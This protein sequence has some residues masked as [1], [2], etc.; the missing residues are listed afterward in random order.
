MFAPV[1]PSGLVTR[2]P[3]SLGP[4]PAACPDGWQ[5]WERTQA[6]LRGP[7]EAFLNRRKCT[8]L[9]IPIGFGYSVICWNES[10]S[11]SSVAQQ[12]LALARRHKSRHISCSSKL[13]RSQ[14]SVPGVCWQVP[15]GAEEPAPHQADQGPEGAETL[16]GGCICSVS[17]SKWW[18]C[19]YLQI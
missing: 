9:L 14:L 11:L 15:A 19:Q 12:T 17:W 2:A 13:G 8:E 4:G 5:W 3:F 6:H 10:E 18:L 16:W 1:M 7:R